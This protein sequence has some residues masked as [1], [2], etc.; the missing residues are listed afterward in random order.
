MDQKFSLISCHECVLKWMPQTMAQQRWRKPP[1]MMRCN[2]C[3]QG[4]IFR[5][6]QYLCTNRV[7]VGTRTTKTDMLYQHAPTMCC[8]ELVPVF[9]CGWVWMTSQRV[10]ESRA[11]VAWRGEKQLRVTWPHL[12]TV[13]SP[14]VSCENNVASFVLFPDVETIDVF[15]MPRAQCT[16]TTWVENCV[17]I[18]FIEFWCASRLTLTH[19][20]L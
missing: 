7:G 11:A 1:A 19:G 16:S 17:F 2:G 3:G 4:C 5:Y 13:S 8:W 14:G 20:L 6:L 12:Q 10:G 9:K 15:N 18:G